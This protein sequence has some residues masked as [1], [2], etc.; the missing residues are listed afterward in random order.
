MRVLIVTNMFPSDEHPSD[1]IFVKRQIDALK[2]ASSGIEIEVCYIDTVR[3]KGAYVY[4]FVAVLSSLYRFRP[5][6]IHIHYGLTQLMC[7]PIIRTPVVVTF[8]GSD[9][10]IPWQRAISRSACKRK[11]KLIVVADRL[12]EYLSSSVGA[13]TIPCGVDS[14]KFLIDREG[15]KRELGFADGECVL[16]FGSNPGRS[17]KRYDRFEACVA[18]LQG[19]IENVR[20]VRLSDVPVSDAPK[21]IAASD[22]LILTSDREGSPIVTKEA[23]CAGTR[24]VS[25]PVGDVAEQFQGFSGCGVSSWDPADLADKVIAVLGQRRPDRAKAA[26]VYDH[27]VESHR[28]IEVYQSLVYA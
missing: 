10:T 20:A 9:L 8:H 25:T 21:L 28:L 17:V 7:W 1:G 3:N 4:G 19:R 12:R 27:S 26:K 14:K 6:V 11:W 23:L 2:G 15:A 5:D 24:V 16:L 18:N 22:V 13:V